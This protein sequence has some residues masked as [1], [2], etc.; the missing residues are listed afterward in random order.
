MDVGVDIRK[1]F[2]TYGNHIAVELSEE[3]KRQLFLPRGFA[4]GY[5]VLSKS[6]VFAYKVDNKYAPEY[7]TGIKYNDKELN[8]NWGLNEKDIKLSEKDKNLSLFKDLDSP[9][10]F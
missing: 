1:G 9:F 6:A 3:N 4:H 10:K 8:I 2:P 7:D 5:V